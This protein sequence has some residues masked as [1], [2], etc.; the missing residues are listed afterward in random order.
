MVVLDHIDAEF[1]KLAWR[2]ALKEFLRRPLERLGVRCHLLVARLRKLTDRSEALLNEDIVTLLDFGHSN[3][4]LFDSHIVHE[5]IDTA[6]Q[7]QLRTLIHFNVYFCAH[8]FLSS[9]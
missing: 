4:D 2:E 6:L 1:D 5:S 7:H 8:A 3:F 9:Q